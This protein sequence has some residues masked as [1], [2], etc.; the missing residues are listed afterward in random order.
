MRGLWW[1]VSELMKAG[2]CLHQ[3]YGHF[4]HVVAQR[5]AAEAVPYMRA[6]LS[7]PLLSVAQILLCVFV[8]TRHVR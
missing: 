1:L 5:E 4:E 8:E 2:V 6:L 3:S 7:N